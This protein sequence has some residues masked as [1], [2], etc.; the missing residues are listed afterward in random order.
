MECDDAPGA[1]NPLCPVRVYNK[2]ATG[3]YLK[4]AEGLGCRRL[5][6]CGWEA[7]CR[8]MAMR[9]WSSECS[10]NGIDESEKQTEVAS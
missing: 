3:D 4:N 8:S 2:S 9:D 10:V 7:Q 5:Y 1:I 6:P